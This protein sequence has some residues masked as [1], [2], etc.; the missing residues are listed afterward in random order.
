MSF[1]SGFESRDRVAVYHSRWQFDVVIYCLMFAT[2]VI[3]AFCCFIG[4]LFV[5]AFNCGVVAE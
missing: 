2:N 1:M 3:L 4:F 5:M